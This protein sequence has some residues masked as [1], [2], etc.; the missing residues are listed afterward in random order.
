MTQQEINSDSLEINANFFSTNF[1]GRVSPLIPHQ[2]VAGQT[3][4]E[5]LDRNSE[6]GRENYKLVIAHFCNAGCCQRC[7]YIFAVSDP[8]L[9]LL[10]KVETSR[11]RVETMIFPTMPSAASIPHFP[12]TV[13]PQAAQRAAGCEY[14][15]APT[16]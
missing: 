14:T 2:G 11:T 1:N 15:P 7:T 8:S 4:A 16:E 9:A 3:H 10:K 13:T 6:E 12:A 5:E